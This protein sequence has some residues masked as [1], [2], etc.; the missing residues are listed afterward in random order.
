[1]RV[2]QWACNFF[3]AAGGSEPFDRV[4]ELA[5]DLRFWQATCVATGQEIRVPRRSGQR[6]NPRPRGPQKRNHTM[7]NHLRMTV[8]S[9]VAAAA[10]ALA[11]P[12]GAQTTP[13]PVTPA[14]AKSP[15]A[16]PMTGHHK[17]GAAKAAHHAD[18]K[19]ECQA[20]MARK[21]EMKARHLEMD[22]TLDK[23][24]ADMNAAKGSMEKPMAAVIN[25]LVAQRKALGSM[26]M[27]MQPTMMAH[28]MR[29]M[30]MSGAKG[31]MECPMM[32]TGKAPE[33]GMGD[34]K[35]KM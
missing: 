15:Q 11:A 3:N 9:L 5:T 18:M 16:A 4:S 12:A 27:E 13:P 34:M 31:A 33:P 35:H 28:M 20:M 24:V 23:L 30:E 25:E 2:L 19:A 17:E 29:H 7:K 10:L 6:L 22:A 26:M 14:T 32:K 1:M 21:E 8:P